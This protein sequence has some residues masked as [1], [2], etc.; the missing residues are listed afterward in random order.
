MILKWCIIIFKIKHQISNMKIMN[1]RQIQPKKNL[2][3]SSTDENLEYY[4][5]ENEGPGKIFHLFPQYSI[6]F[7]LF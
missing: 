2:N 7:N 1:E 6:C 5:D 3:F 4:D